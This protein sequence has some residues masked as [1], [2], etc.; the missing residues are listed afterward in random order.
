[1]Y[2]FVICWTTD[3]LND[4]FKTKTYNYV[5]ELKEIDKIILEC[6]DELVLDH[7]EQIQWEIKAESFNLNKFYEMV[8]GQPYWD[9]IFF[10]VKYFDITDK[11]WKDYEI[12]EEK[13]NVHIMA[14][15]INH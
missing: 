6:I 11:I 15:F 4:M 13:L 14:H 10:S 2:P 8:N 5:R 1:M 12:D 3:D 9:Y 7:K